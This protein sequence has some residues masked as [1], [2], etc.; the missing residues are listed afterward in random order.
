MQRIHVRTRLAMRAL[1][2]LHA[3]LSVS[4]LTL[5]QSDT[6]TGEDEDCVGS[7]D[8]ILPAHEAQSGTVQ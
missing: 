5:A 6:Y 1:L 2:A 3:I 7:E 8:D 4:T